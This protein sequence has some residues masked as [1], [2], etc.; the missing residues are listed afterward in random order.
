MMAKLVLI[1]ME[2]I[3]MV[4]TLIQ[5]EIRFLLILN[6]RDSLL[7]NQG[8]N[9]S[10]QSVGK[11]LKDSCFYKGLLLWSAGPAGG[12]NIVPQ[13]ASICQE[14][15]RRKNNKVFLPKSVDIYS[16]LVYYIIVKRARVQWK[17]RG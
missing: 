12:R 10:L 9:S 8:E 3:I 2:A 16:L 17:Y 13:G 6:I 11:F 7:N 5:F 4:C 15:K 14:K 1:F